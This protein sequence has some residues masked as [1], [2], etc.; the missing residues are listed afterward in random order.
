VDS[1]TTGWNYDEQGPQRDG[2]GTFAGMRGNDGVAPIPAV[3]GIAIESREATQ[4]R[5]WPREFGA[6][7]T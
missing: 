7:A 3:R 1:N 2:E 4:L 6:S 5:H